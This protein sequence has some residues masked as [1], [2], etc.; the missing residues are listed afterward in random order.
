MIL[1]QRY[2]DDG[3]ATKDWW[4]RPIAAKMATLG[5]RR[6]RRTDVRTTSLDGPTDRNQ[7]LSPFIF[8]LSLHADHRDRRRRVPKTLGRSLFSTRARNTQRHHLLP[9]HLDV[10]LRRQFDQRDGAPG[11]RKPD[12]VRNAAMDVRERFDERAAA[13]RAAKLMRE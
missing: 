8:S 6:L 4:L 13:L 5:L 11:I 10:S 1:K 9:I 12:Q 3:S 2:F 7:L